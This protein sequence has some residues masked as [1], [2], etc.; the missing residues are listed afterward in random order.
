MPQNA[1]ETTPEV[2]RE[3]KIAA[4]SPVCA[5]TET[6]TT[7]SRSDAL[8]PAKTP[9]A[10][11]KARPVPTGRV[12]IHTFEPLYTS[13]DRP[14]AILRRAG[15]ETEM[16]HEERDGQVY[17]TIRISQAPQRRH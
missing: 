13:L 1:A 5:T 9:P 15:C 14:L 6:C 8:L 2:P 11:E 16:Q 7:L 3:R 12:A 10:A 17:I 4:F